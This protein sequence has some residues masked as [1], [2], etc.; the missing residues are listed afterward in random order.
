MEILNTVDQLFRYRKANNFSL[1]E[2]ED[3]Y[4]YFPSNKDLNDPFDTNHMMLR[5]TNEDTEMEK[6]YNQN[7]DELKDVSMRA[8]FKK[9][10]KNKPDEFRKYVENETINVISTC[11]I[12]CFTVS[13]IHIV[14]WATYADNHEGICIQYDTLRDRSFF[15]GVRK[16]DYVEKLEIIDY[17]PFSNPEVLCDV[18][19]K[20]LNLWEKEY[21]VR[22]VKPK[23][24]KYKINPE[25]L[26]SIVLGIR[27]KDDYIEKVKD[28]V[29][30]KYKHATLYQAE[31]MTGSVGLSLIPID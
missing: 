21:E 30:R 12:A 16:I 11:G 20:K 8:Y 3:G 15:K 24:G 22:L 1:E 7:I 6:V 17:R 19:Y 13:P 10:Y 23:N 28:I 5:L 2:L 18:F 14:L 26:R 4:I 27:V 9:L 31:V 25:C 29:R